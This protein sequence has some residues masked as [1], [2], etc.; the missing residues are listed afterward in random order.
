MASLDDES[1]EHA[2]RDFMSMSLC[3]RRLSRP[4]S[5]AQCVRSRQSRPNFVR[6]C[7]MSLAAYAPEQTA[8][9]QADAAG[10]SA[11]EKQLA[12]QHKQPAH[13]S[14]LE[15]KG[16]KLLIDGDTVLLEGLAPT[17]AVK[18]HDAGGVVLGFEVANGAVASYDF[19]VGK[20]LYNQT[21]NHP[22]LMLHVCTR[23]VHSMQPEVKEVIQ[24]ADLFPLS[25]LPKKTRVRSN[26]IQCICIRTSMTYWIK[27]WGFS[28]LCNNNPTLA[29]L[30]S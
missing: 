25:F 7:R 16:S 13:L 8:P 14:Q 21:Q 9:K 2:T 6:G 29:G 30:C 1:V 24:S 10:Q 3:R 22:P 11:I 17:T 12:L 26:A 5:K 19:P 27:R 15:R 20:V 18:R 23:A 28:P 4:L